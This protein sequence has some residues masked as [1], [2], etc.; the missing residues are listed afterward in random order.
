M[1]HL[2]FVRGLFPPRK[3]VVKHV[4]VQHCLGHTHLQLLRIHCGFLSRGKSLCLGNWKGRWAGFQVTSGYVTS[5][6]WLPLSG[7]PFPQL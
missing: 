6:K 4:P 1:P 3:V 5:G 7:P 2:G